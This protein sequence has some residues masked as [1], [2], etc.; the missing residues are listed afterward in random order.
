[1]GESG[2]ST[3]IFSI[4]KTTFS[5]PLNF[6]NS[7]PHKFRA[8]KLRSKLR[9]RQSPAS[10]IASVQTSFSPFITLRALRAHRWSIYDAQYLFLILIG[11]I[12]A[13]NKSITESIAE[14]GCCGASRCCSPRT[15]HE[16]I[17]PPISTYINMACILFFMP[18]SNYP[19]FSCPLLFQLFSL[20][21][22][23][24]ENRTSC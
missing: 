4:S 11:D 9:A 10:S 6:S 8:H 3:P 20:L 19:P 13:V 14:D 2:R 15:R 21:P 23:R 24:S 17:F 16:P 22:K 12:R 7:L 18:V 5:W 1:M